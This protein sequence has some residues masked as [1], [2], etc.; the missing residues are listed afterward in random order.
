MFGNCGVLPAGLQLVPD[1]DLADGLLDLAM[2]ET[3]HGLAG[4]AALATQVVLNG[5]GFR[6]MP[7]WASGRLW[8]EQAPRFELECDRDHKVQL[9]GELV[10]AARRLEVWVDPL[11]LRIRLPKPK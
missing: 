7:A 11:A 3:R 1:A 8:Y 5:V 9:D 6:W 2:A 10:G 4:W